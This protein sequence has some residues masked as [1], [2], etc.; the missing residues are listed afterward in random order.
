MCHEYMYGWLRGTQGGGE[1][2][3]ER[4]GRVEVEE[5]KGEGNRERMEFGKGGSGEDIPKLEEARM[6]W[7]D[8]E[9]REEGRRLMRKR[10]SEGLS[11]EE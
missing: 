4:F 11:K 8:R 1:R 2:L 6:T 10:G 5:G 9:R 3:G 7:R